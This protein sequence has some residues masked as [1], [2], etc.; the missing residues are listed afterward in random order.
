MAP[1]W[2][3]FYPVFDRRPISFTVLASVPAP[4]RF[5]LKC[6]KCETEIES[7]GMAGGNDLEL[8]WLVVLM[9][10]GF[11]VQDREKT[12]HLIRHKLFKPPSP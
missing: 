3:R 10:H 8:V 4:C 1:F 6:H 2:R 11:P 5:G 12:P 9:L 7:I